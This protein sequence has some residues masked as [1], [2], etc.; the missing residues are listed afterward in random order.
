MPKG[1]VHYADTDPN[2]EAF[3]LTIGIHRQNLQWIDV[4]HHLLHSGAK[5]QPLPDGERR[6]GLLEELMQ[7]YSE[8]AEGVHLHD[9][10]L[11]YLRKRL[12]AGELRAQHAKVVEGMVSAA[13]DRM[14]A[15]GR[16]L[17]D[18]GIIDQCT[19]AGEEIDW[20]CCCLGY[21]K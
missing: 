16:G 17:Q 6:Q 7:V 13:A 10:I 3:H 15:T 14:K 5:A 4:V 18:T 2:E 8:T 19:F 21:V 12:T 11:Q 20:Y 9:I 1:V